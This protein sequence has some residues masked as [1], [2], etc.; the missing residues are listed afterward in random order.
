MSGQAAFL[1]RLRMGVLTSGS[2]ATRQLGQELADCLPD[3]TVLALHGNLGTGKT[4]FISGL[5]TGLGITRPVTSPTYNIYNLYRGRRQLVHL[6]AYRLEQADEAEG[7]ML[8]D[9]L[10]SPWLLAVEWP[11]RFSPEWLRRAWRLHFSFEGENE[12][13]IRLE[14]DSR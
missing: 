12:R 14:S 8:E 11:E 2:D 3:D 10:E 5:A 7:L 6:D 13:L 9:L 4:T 1:H